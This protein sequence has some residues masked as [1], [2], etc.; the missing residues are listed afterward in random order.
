MG[1]RVGKVRP[2]VQNP[3]FVGRMA[4]DLLV[5]PMPGGAEFNESRGIGGKPY[6]KTPRDSRDSL[7]GI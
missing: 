7:C 5:A 2:C 4:R 1:A 3:F 6:A